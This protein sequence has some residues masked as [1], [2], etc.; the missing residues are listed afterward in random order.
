MAV[1]S[2]TIHALSAVSTATLTTILP[3]NHQRRRRCHE[4]LFNPQP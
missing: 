4:G 2:N 3:K 1:D